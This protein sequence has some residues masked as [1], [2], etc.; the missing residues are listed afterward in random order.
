VTAKGD[1]PPP[2]LLIGTRGWEHAAWT[3]EFYPE[4]LP[5]EWRLTFYANY[6]DSVLVPPACWL[7]SDLQ[8]L[9]QWLEDTGDEFRFVLELPD[10]HDRHQENIACRTEI[11]GAR[12]AALVVPYAKGDTV[13]V[14]GRFSRWPL[15]VR[16][17]G[18]LAESERAVLTSAGASILWDPAHTQDPVPGGQLLVIALSAPDDHVIAITAQSLARMRADFPRVAFFV[19]GPPSMGEKA[20]AAATLLGLWP[21]DTRHVEQAT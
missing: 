7:L 19:D 4:A 18:G 5:L 8:V 3:P 15:S 1:L 11:L 2:G 14:I 13:S 12:I 10:D 9:D 6:F 21:P 16:V 17:P 20:R